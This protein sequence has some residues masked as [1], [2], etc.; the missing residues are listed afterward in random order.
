MTTAGYVQ[1]IWNEKCSWLKRKPTETR[2]KPLISA[3]IFKRDHARKCAHNSL[4]YRPK[5]TGVTLQFVSLSGDT[6]NAWAR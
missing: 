1:N 2:T 6:S 5:V 4:N 3:S